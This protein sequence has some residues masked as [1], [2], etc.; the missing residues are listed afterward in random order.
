MRA[1]AAGALAA[2]VGAQPGPPG[3]G[4][5]Q[6]GARRWPCPSARALQVGELSALREPPCNE[7]SQALE[8]FPRSPQADAGVKGHLV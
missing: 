4:T 1:G 3:A 2:R 6:T 7:A 5:R 8:V